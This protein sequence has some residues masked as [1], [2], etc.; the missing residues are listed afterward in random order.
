MA[1]YTKRTWLARLGTGLNRYFVNN[2]RYE[3][4]VNS[5]ESIT[6]NG[7]LLSADNLN[8]LETRIENGFNSIPIGYTFVVDSQQKYSDLCNNVSGNDYTHVVIIGGKGA[9]PNGEYTDVSSLSLST[10]GIKTITGINNP[11]LQFAGYNNCIYYSSSASTKPTNINEYSIKNITAERIGT[12]GSMNGIFFNCY[13]L[14]NC[15][16]IYNSTASPQ[17]NRNIEGFNQCINLTNCDLKNSIYFYC[18][19]LKNCNAT[20][21]TST[22]AWNTRV[23][24]VYYYCNG[25]DSCDGTI[26][27]ST[28]T[29]DA[30]FYSCNY[31]KNIKLSKSNLPVHIFEL[32]NYLEDVEITINNS[33][34][35][36]RAIYN[37]MSCHYLVNCKVI[38]TANESS[39]Y[40]RGFYSC[41]NLV[42]CEATITNSNYI[43]RAFQDCKRVTLCKGTGVGNS[44]Y[45]SGGFS[46]CYCVTQSGPN[47]HSTSGVFSTT[48]ATNTTNSTYAAA[49]T[50]NGGFNNTINPS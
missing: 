29:D 6:Q 22:S 17:D 5:P 23:Y 35:Y 21:D 49:D 31:I 43:A 2:S 26:T 37:F 25:L 3:Y 20:I 8:D 16:A 10:R 40:C 48:Y 30:I 47:G 36:N 42:N 44:G 15:K 24:G 18:N 46:D 39:Y 34:R 19:N 38:A 14:E 7:D 45:W 12:G 9:G 13:N 27:N 28:A 1:I 41:G 33:T 11:I 4:L 32:C 50:A